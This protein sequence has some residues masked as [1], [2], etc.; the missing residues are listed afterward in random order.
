MIP[1]DAAIL[2]HIWC[3]ILLQERVTTYELYI[4]QIFYFINTPSSRNLVY[5]NNEAQI[6][7]NLLAAA[8]RWS[9]KKVLLKLSQNSQEN[10][11]TRVFFNKIAGLRPAT[12]LNKRFWQRCLPVNFENLFLWNTTGGCFWKFKY[13]LRIK[14]FSLNA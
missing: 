12:L 9:V 10:T 2:R 13:K 11:C 4:F 3:Y 6:C 7:E 1:I 8:W 14:G 5:Q